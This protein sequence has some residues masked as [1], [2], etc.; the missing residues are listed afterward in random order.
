L[1]LD[2]QAICSE[3]GL[4]TCFISTKEIRVLALDLQLIG[5]EYGL[6]I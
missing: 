5:A 3:Y 4:K 1:A 2:F 6:E